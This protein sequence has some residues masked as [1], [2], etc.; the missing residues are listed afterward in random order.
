MFGFLVRS[1]ILVLLTTLVWE[2]VRSERRRARTI[3]TSGR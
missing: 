2:I 3:L 1:L